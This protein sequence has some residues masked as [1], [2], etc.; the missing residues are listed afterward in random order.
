M[1]V[2][3]HI[4]FLYPSP[5]SSGHSVVTFKILGQKITLLKK[6]HFGEQQQSKNFLRIAV[7][8]IYFKKKKKASWI[9][10][11]WEWV[12]ARET[13]E[14]WKNTRFL[15]AAW[16][17]KVLRLHFSNYIELLICMLIYCTQTAFKHPHLRTEE[18]STSRHC[19]AWN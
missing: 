10:G 12:I 2:F 6:M 19:S 9:V 17:M 14:K 8:L 11:I 16:R 1:E 7:T 3:I 13:V 15:C 5:T 4:F 18:S